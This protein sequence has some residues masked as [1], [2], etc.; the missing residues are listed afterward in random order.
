MHMRLDAENSMEGW[1]IVEL[2]AHPGG[3]YLFSFA[4]FLDVIAHIPRTWI[5]LRHGAR[6]ITVDWAPME[7]PG[8]LAHPNF[9]HHFESDAR[10]DAFV[11]LFLTK[12]EFVREI[13]GPLSM[14]L[15][16]AAMPPAT[17][18]L[19]LEEWLQRGQCIHI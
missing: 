10:T 8:V 15:C 4:W 1:Q 5:L 17:S 6:M 18:L 7:D 13:K 14:V 9:V 3:W 2:G 11:L 12:G 16:D 19:V